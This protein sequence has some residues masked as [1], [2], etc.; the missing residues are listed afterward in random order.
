MNTKRSLVVSHLGPDINNL[1]AGC[2]PD[3]DLVVPDNG[4]PRWQLPA[5]TRILITTPPGWKGAPSERPADWPTGLAWIQLESV[6]IDAFPKWLLKDVTVTSARGSNAPSIAEYVMAEILGT[7]KRVHET[8]IRGPSE[9]KQIRMGS[10]QGKVLG[11]AGFGAI[12]QALAE[13][14]RAFGMKVA[15]FR[16]SAWTDAPPDVE[17]VADINA[18][19]ACSDHLVLAM[20]ATR[21]TRHIV[22]RESL[23]RA[24]PGLHLINVARGGLVD[25]D[26]LLDALQQGHLA[27]AT[28]DVTEPEPL[29]E[30]HPFYTHPK[31]RITSHLAWDGDGNAARMRGIIAENLER[32]AAGK[33]L[34]NVI[35]TERGY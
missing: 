18:L 5:R 32:F 8:G 4:T 9:W 6:G 10:P 33:P 15:A 34:I 28:L 21:E 29:P 13:R 26:A 22:N 31:V 27:R 20:P 2:A 23:A 35:D 17:P 24:K 3:L 11:I 12:G 7:E 25:Q 1:I 30:G 14:A 16:R 19:F